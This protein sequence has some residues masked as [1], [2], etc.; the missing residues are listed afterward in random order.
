MSAANTAAY[1]AEDYVGAVHARNVM[2]APSPTSPSRP[3][4]SVVPTVATAARHLVFWAAC[5]ALLLGAILLRLVINTQMAVV[6]FEIHEQRIALS[7]VQD[8]TNTLVTQVQVAASPSM[9]QQRA[10]AIGMVQGNENGFIFLSTGT[11]QGG[12][13]ASSSQ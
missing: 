3:K 5:V 9:L 1:G 8:T 12:K 4:L 11:V 6:S 7:K 2:Y 13:P 10:Q